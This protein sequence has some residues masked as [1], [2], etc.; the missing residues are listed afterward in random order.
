LDASLSFLH[1]VLLL[2]QPMRTKGFTG[3]KY[4][5]CLFE[6]PPE[7]SL[8]YQCCMVHMPP[9]AASSLTTSSSSSSSRLSSFPVFTPSCLLCC[10]AFAIE[11]HDPCFNMLHEELHLGSVQSTDNMMYSCVVS[12]QF[13]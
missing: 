3:K 11:C 4:R 2:P 13:I 7:T 1:E 6:Q 12:T 10:V 5:I 9:A 8:N